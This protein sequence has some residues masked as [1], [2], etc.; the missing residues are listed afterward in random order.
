MKNNFRYL[1]IIFFVLPQLFNA[2]PIFCA[3]QD[4]IKIIESNLSKEKEKFKKFDSREKDL[5]RLISNLETEISEKKRSVEIVK[6]QIRGRAAEIKKLKKSQARLEKSLDRAETEAFKRLVALYKYARKGYLKILT[7]F[8]D[9]QY[10]WK[11]LVYLKAISNLDRQELNIILEKCLK[12]RNNLKELQ[13]KIA[14]E[15][16]TKKKQSNFLISMK[17]DLEKKVIQLMRIHQEKE[18]YETA[19]Q[20]LRIA[21]QDM[22]QALVNIEKKKNYRTAWASK[23]KDAKKKIPFPVKGEVI[24][25][26]KLLGN[27]NLNS[28]KGVFIEGT[29]TSVKAVFPGRVDYS[30][31]L[32][33]Y[34]EVVIINHGSRYYTISAFLSSRLKREGQNVAAGEVIGTVVFQGE[35]KK[36]KLYFEIRQGG[37]SLN[38]M[39]WFKPL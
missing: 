4:Q 39:R 22:K 28:S 15:E 16:S 26:E 37:K 11:G 13:E 21:A 32:K 25:R 5:L 3:V 12:Y 1:L 30:G 9:R 29:D 36:T 24:R 20:E 2:S 8:Y 31:R 6:E 35:G 14:Y 23:F 10:F 34:G 19:V 18:F 33:G 7:N 17:E 27:N 38:P